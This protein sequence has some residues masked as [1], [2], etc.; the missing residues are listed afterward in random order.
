MHTFTNRIANALN[1]RPAQVENT[2]TLFAE[3]ATVTFIS[4]YRK[5]M[6]GS[7]DEVEIMAIK[8][9]QDKYV[10]VEKRRDAIVKAIEE[11]GKMTDELR[12]QI[13]KATELTTLED[14]YL[15]Y[16]RSRKNPCVA[17]A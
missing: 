14:I 11:Q 12:A 4:R 15:P 3:G 7:L 1:L 2:L 6:T 16:K 9:L 17:G 13:Q 5:E 8:T 10:E